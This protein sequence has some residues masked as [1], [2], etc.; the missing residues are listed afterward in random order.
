MNGDAAYNEA[1]PHHSSIRKNNDLLHF[2]SKEKKKRNEKERRSAEHLSIDLAFLYKQPRRQ[3][4]EYTCLV[5]RYKCM[6]VEHINASYL[7]VF[8]L[9]LI[10]FSHGGRGGEAWNRKM[11][12]WYACVVSEKLTIQIG[13]EDNWM[14]KR[15]LKITVA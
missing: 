10:F 5:L 12:M 13:R 7:S 15:E 4:R 11:R 8:L 2:L 9:S 1:H 14:K 6:T 3:R